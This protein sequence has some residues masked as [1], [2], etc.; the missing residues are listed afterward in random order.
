MTSRWSVAAVAAGTLALAAL[1]GGSAIRGQAGAPAQAS[2][3]RSADGPP[4]SPAQSLATLKVE[5]GFRVELVASEPDVQSPV[6]M[7]ID[8]DGRMFVVEMPGYPLDVSATGRVKLL[9]DTDG[10]GRIDRSIVYADNLRLPSGVMRYR[11]GILVTSPPDLLYFEDLNG[12]GKADRREVVLT[13]FARTNPQHAVN[14]P[15]YGLDNWIYL[16]HS[17]G[18]EPVIYR[19][20]FGDKGRDL[21]FPERPELPGVDSRGR[22]V[23]VKPDAGQ[24]EGLSSRTQFGNAFD[25]YGRFF[26]HNNSIHARHEVIAARYL[27]RNPHLVLP[28]AM[29]D[30]SDHG[31]NNIMP[32]TH[33]ARF[34][35]LTEAGQFTSACGFTVYA[36][37]AFP[38]GFDGVSFVA[39]PVH[40]LIHR[41][42]LSPKGSTFAASRGRDDMEFLAST[43]SWFR[44]VNLYVG[45]DGALYVI[46]YYRPYIEHPEWSSSDLQRNPDVLSTG[47]DRGRIYRVVAASAAAG[48]GNPAGARPALGSATDAQLVEALTHRNIWWRRTAQRLLVTNRRRDAVPALERLADQRP[49]ALARLHALWTLEGLG[50]LDPPR[51]L[52]ALGD[53]DPGVRENAIVLAERWLKEPAVSE[54][55]IALADSLT[56]QSASAAGPAGARLPFQMLATL[57]SL[58]TPASRAAQERLLLAGIEDEWIQA[59]A[60]SASS[61]RAASWLDRA[62]QPGSPFTAAESAGRARF[63]ERIGGIIAARERATELTRAIVVVSDA[64]APAGD[65]WRAALLEGIARGLTGARDRQRLVG[66][67]DA[68]LTLAIADQP[69]LRRAAVTL[70]GVSGI[71][72]GPRAAAAVARATEIAADRGRP[73]EFR[74]DAL[75]LLTL[76]D[77]PAHRRLFEA[78]LDG[79]EPEAVQIAGVNALGKIPGEA[80]PAFLLAKWPALTPSVRSAAATVILARR[81]GAQ[82]MLDALQ[83]GAAKPWMLNFWQKR[84]LIMNRDERIR[85]TARTVLEESP[86]ARARTVARYAAALGGRGDAARGAE[87]FART[88]SMCHQVDGRNGV[89]MG[90]DLAT[91]RHRPMPVLLADILEPS[92]SI[93][94]HY[95]TYQVERASGE[96]LIGV[97]G[98]QSPAAITFRQG[99]GQSTTLRRADIRQMRVIPQ[100]AMPEALD[101]QVSPE[102]MAH[103][104][105]FLTTPPAREPRPEAQAGAQASAQA[106]A[107]LP[108]AATAAPEAIAAALLDAGRDQKARETLARDAAPRAMDVVRALV[109]GMPDEEAEEYRRIPW[110]WRVAVAAGRAKD[111]G[112]LRALMDGATPRDGE[113]LRDWQAVVLGGGVVMGLSQSGAWPGDVIAPWLAADAALA[114]RWARTLDLA[115]AMA[116]NA[117][118]RDGTRY[119]ALRMLGVLPWSRVGAQL[120]RYLGDGIAAEL[121]AGAIGGLS[122]LQDAQA[123][124]ALASNAARVVPANRR[125]VI[126][127]LL[128]TDARRAILRD[129]LAKGL[130]KDEWLTPEQRA[131]R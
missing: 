66:S 35:L 30:I 43:D 21:T 20:L 58:D 40:N 78:A 82:A 52:Q 49:S 37:G 120:T 123:A 81:E 3:P 65:W 39:E 128:R 22:G 60:L 110:I 101:Q 79:V 93:A 27:E 88:C 51:V 45:P 131:R 33:G 12:D 46:D 116:D 15:V 112:A 107:V 42:V 102:E 113:R 10:D 74:A 25:V 95:E 32:I 127:A 75:G 62:L 80:T 105:V 67:Q 8:E 11:K 2:A 53:P 103:L 69:R 34:D 7:D 114:A 14:H 90:P 38:D 26:A 18:S 44:P 19:D 84:S 9:E 50:R 97:I 86:E 119:D 16:A 98:E 6:A 73:A 63:I 77:A 121:Q 24:V 99:P 41:D 111:D 83:S 29:A 28:S 117:T 100:S 126:D 61:D 55:V 122:D 108:V 124:T 85:A 130:I 129:A 125:H 48:S 104:L 76:A 87:V 36:G 1:A 118:V 64:S 92:R 56:T 89:E 57:G 47:K 109:A 91:V 106:S 31:N 68:L 4:Y 23:R 70:L 17:G 72:P 54:A 71:E 13:G 59:A 5:P 94:Q 115:I 96:T